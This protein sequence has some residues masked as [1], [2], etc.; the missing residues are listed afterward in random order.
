MARNSQPTSSNYDFDVKLE[1]AFVK[2]SDGSESKINGYKATRRQ[3]TGKVLG[4]VGSDYGLVRTGDLTGMVED[5]FARKGL[6]DY[7]RRAVVARDGAR[8][9]VEYDFKNHLR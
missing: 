7:T 6:V 3:D 4:I 5:G 1:D 2:N 8:T 9:Y